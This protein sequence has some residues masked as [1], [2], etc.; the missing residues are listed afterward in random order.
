MFGDF[1][2]NGVD[3]ASSHLQNASLL[4]HLML[5][6]VLLSGWLIALGEHL[7]RTGQTAIVDR[8]YRRDLSL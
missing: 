1:K 6:V 4:D 3:G 7:I 8:V 2:D 5:A